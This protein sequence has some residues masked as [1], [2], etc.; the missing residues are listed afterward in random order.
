[1]QFSLPARLRAAMGYNV[2][3]NGVRFDS[4]TSRGRRCH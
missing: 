2:A 1:V 4:I 3:F